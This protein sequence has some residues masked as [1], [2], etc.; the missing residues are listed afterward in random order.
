MRLLID[1]NLSPKWADFLEGAGY[2]ATHW[3]KLGA[4]D[5]TDPELMTFATSHGYVIIT[6]DLFGAILA[7]TQGMGP[8]VVQVRADDLDP[9][10][11]GPQIV[12]ALHQAGQALTEGALVTVDPARSRITLLPINREISGNANAHTGEL[13]A[14]FN[15]D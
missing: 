12:A 1:M 10:A 3:S 4:P 13:P 2:E 11:I 5:A 15:E 9:A 6:H 8:S 7:A 14:S